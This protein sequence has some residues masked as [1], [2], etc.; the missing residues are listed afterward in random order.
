MH[1][2]KYGVRTMSKE[3]EDKL[4]AYILFA[5]IEEIVENCNKQVAEIYAGAEHYQKDDGNCLDVLLDSLAQRA[6]STI[7][8]SGFDNISKLIETS[9]H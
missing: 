3:T 4:R 9:H 5:Q 7:K 6:L 8:A 1:S 2:K